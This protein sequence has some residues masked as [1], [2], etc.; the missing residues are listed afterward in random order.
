MSLLA[1]KYISILGA[2]TSTFDGYSNN[3]LHNATITGN[4][5][6][7]PKEFLNDVNDTWWMKTINA[8]D[9]KLCVNN[10]WSGSCVTAQIDHEQSAACM[11]RATELHNDQLNIDPDIIILI[12]GGNDA[13]RGYDIGS[14]H[15]VRDVYDPQASTYI[16]DCSLFGPA[17]ATMVHKVKNRYPSADIYVCSMLYWKPKRHDKGLVEYNSTVQKIAA[18]FGVTYVDFYNQTAISPG[19]SPLY[20]H[21]DGVHPKEQGFE[22]MS[23]CLVALLKSRYA[24]A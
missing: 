2:S 8:L 18:E 23:N 17:Y 4:A 22:E 15:T 5:T 10:S 14:Y 13:L 12:I 1:G 7:Y 3:A 16:G 19:T 21:T 9:L 20:L 24:E 6:Y 11:T